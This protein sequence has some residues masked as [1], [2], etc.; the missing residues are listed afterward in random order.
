MKTRTGILIGLGVVAAV[1]TGNMVVGSIRTNGDLAKIAG[2]DAASRTVGVR[3]LISRG[4]LFDALQGGAPLATRLNAIAA[5]QELAK[6][7]DN[8]AAFRELIQLLKDPDTESADART[9]PV[10]DAA[11]AALI[12]TGAAY[13]DLILNAAKDPDTNIRLQSIEVLKKIGAPLQSA[14]AAKMGDAALR[15]PCGEV[16]AIIGPSSIPL[17]TP[18]LSPDKLKDS[19]TLSKLALI[20]ALGRYKSPD[21]AIPII[22]FENDADPNVRRAVVTALSNIADPAGAAVLIRSAMSQDSDASARAAAAGALGT[23]AT[24]EACAAL[25]SLLGDNDTFVANAAAAG[26]LRAG[27]RAQSRIQVAARD[28]DPAVRRR[29][30]EASG[31]LTSPGAASTLAN[32][33]DPTVRRTAVA[34]LANILVKRKSGDT[35]AVEMGLLAKKLSDPDGSVAAEASSGLAKL[36]PSAIPTLLAALAGDDTSAFQASQALATIGKPAVDS[37]IRLASSGK[38]SARWAAATLGEIGNG[39]ASDVLATL[40]NSN[41]PDTAYVAKIALRK[42]SAVGG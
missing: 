31:G 8:P 37:L 1:A 40:A 26:L 17:V 29:A 33:P 10:R 12:E 30:A 35:P 22:R 25:S 34:A 2:T 21:A 38:T 28:A 7:G 27:D 36:G 9:H 42:V 5:L 32:D 4:V 39:E 41:D 13:P 19:D 16:L 23:I 18:W 11:R 6:S 24:P 20:E 15:V 3:A 14:V